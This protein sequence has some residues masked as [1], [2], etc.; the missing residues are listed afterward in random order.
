[1]SYL[2]HLTDEQ[3]LLYH[4]LL[5]SGVVRSKRFESIKAHGTDLKFLYHVCR[6][7]YE[8]EMILEEQDLDLERNREH[9]KAIRRGEI[10][11]EDIRNWASEKEKHLERLYESSKLQHS[12][13]EEAIKSLLLNCLE[14]HYEGISDAI[15]SEDRYK[16][17]LRQIQGIIGGLKEL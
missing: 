7:L 4:G 10:T 17:A 12:P 3:L 11:E 2:S 5:S 13:D 14:E 9:L 15:V 6:L 8:A 1:M 16:E